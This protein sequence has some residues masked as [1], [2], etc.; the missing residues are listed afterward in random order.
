[1]KLNLIR[2]QEEYLHGYKNVSLFISPEAQK[3]IVLG[4]YA[5]LD[6]LCTANE[7]TELRAIDI[8]DYYNVD[9]Y[10]K[11]VS[12]WTSKL[13]HGGTIIIGGL[14]IIEVNT[15]L[16]NNSISPEEFNTLVF[17]TTTKSWNVKKSLVSIH[18]MG[19]LLLSKGLSLVAKEFDNLHYC[20]TA[21]RP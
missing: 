11:I 17:G 16:Y 7:C 8:L 14:D 6:A 18:Q 19:N 4:D 2:K 15:A 5:N 21:R 3:D 20:I 12:N 1:M 9:Q 10:D 13:R